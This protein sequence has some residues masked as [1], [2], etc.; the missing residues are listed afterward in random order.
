[1]PDSDDVRVGSNGLAGA[2]LAFLIGIIPN[3]SSVQ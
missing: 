3:L 1:M 2:K